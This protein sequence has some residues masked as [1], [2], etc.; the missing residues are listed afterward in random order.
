MIKKINEAFDR[1]FDS[2]LDEAL[3]KDLMQQIRRAGTL[4]KGDD[5]FNTG[6]GQYF[7]ADGIYQDRVYNNETKS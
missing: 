2:A 1:R 3:P 7:N 5:Y 6:G 4:E